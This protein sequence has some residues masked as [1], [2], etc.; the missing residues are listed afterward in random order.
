MT[1]QSQETIIDDSLSLDQD[2]FDDKNETDDNALIV[3]IV[4]ETK[5]PRWCRQRW[6]TWCAWFLLLLLVLWGLS[7]WKLYYV[8]QDWVDTYL[9]DESRSVEM[10]QFTPQEI[11]EAKQRLM[12]INEQLSWTGNVTLVESDVNIRLQQLFV[13]NDTTAI[14]SETWFAVIDLLSWEILVD[15][16]FWL[17]WLGEELWFDL[18][19]KYVDLFFSLSQDGDKDFVLDDLIVN[20]TSIPTNG[21]VTLQVLYY[22]IRAELASKNQSDEEIERILNYWESIKKIIITDDEITFIRE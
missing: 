22:K 20:K 11:D 4:D 6:C 16:S 12:L 19:Q 14:K 18:N 13:K 8:V 1:Q 5:K 2:I 21:E 15:T 17:S 7:A 10:Q 3:D 9:A